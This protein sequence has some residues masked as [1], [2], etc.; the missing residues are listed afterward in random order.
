MIMVMKQLSEIRI[1]GLSTGQI[2]LF[3]ASQNERGVWVEE[4]TEKMN[5]KREG[6]Y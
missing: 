6:V 5:R 1:V 3:G 2:I 4:E